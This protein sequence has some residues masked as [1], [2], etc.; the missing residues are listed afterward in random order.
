M[1]VRIET[2]G[3]V[4]E[5]ALCR[6][7]AGNALTPEMALAIAAAVRAPDPAVTVILLRAEGA[8]FCTG[9]APVMPPKGARMTANDLRA[10]ISEPVLEFYGALRAAPVPLVARVQG[11]ALGV[12]CAL[13]ALADVAIAAPDARFAV[14]EMGHDI[15][16]TLVME[17]LVDRLPRAHLARLV[18]TRDSVSAGEAQAM[19][20]IGL[21]AAD[22][23]GAVE[24]G[25]A[26]L[27]GNSPATVRAV[28]AF[29]LRAPDAPGAVRRE[30]AALLNA[31]ATAEKFR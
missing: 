27:A 31:G 9:R 22:L 15:A 29:L 20:L 8:D 16:P 7:E 19:G 25:V 26:A 4:L 11:R 13:A 28:K 6:G 17:A 14:P 24:R 5:I 12:G 18:L 2:K 30:L 10:L 1:D 23:D 21:V 3:A